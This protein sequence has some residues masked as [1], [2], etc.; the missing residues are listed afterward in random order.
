MLKEKD[1]VTIKGLAE[2]G[3]VKRVYK[4]LNVAIVDVDGDTYKI[5]LDELALYKEDDSEI[6]SMTDKIGEGEITVTGMDFCRAQL[7]VCTPDY[8]KAH[9]ANAEEC[10]PIDWG[11]VAASGAV[12]SNLLWDY[13]RGMK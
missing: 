11:I 10:T 3:T 2:I 12:V 6:G 9:C 7:E 13:L 8:I 5:A 1:K 4:D